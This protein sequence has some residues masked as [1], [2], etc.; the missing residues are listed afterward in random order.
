MN[1]LQ[2][3]TRKLAQGFGVKFDVRD[4][5]LDLVEEVGELSQ[6]IQIESGRKITNDPS[7]ARTRADVVD[8]LCDVMFDLIM[9]AEKYEI[10]M[11]EKYEQML[12]SLQERIDSGEFERREA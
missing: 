9:L 2:E 4:Y 5:L 1:R 8:G 12:L 11:G 3:K 6:A 10:D 7:K